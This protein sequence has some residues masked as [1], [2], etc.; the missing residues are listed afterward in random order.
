MFDF[1][2]KEIQDQMQE[3]GKEFK[4]EEGLWDIKDKEVT[5][6]VK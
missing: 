4:Q 2:M 5:K 6:N 1:L 3:I